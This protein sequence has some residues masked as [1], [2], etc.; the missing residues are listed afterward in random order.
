LSLS[1]DAVFSAFLSQFGQTPVKLRR[2]LFFYEFLN[3][4]HGKLSAKGPAHERQMC[5]NM[6]GQYVLRLQ[7]V[8]N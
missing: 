6:F 8:L 1:P 4:F 5:V 2:G 7:G 3:I